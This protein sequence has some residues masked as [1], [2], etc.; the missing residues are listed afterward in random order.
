MVEE[1]D[2]YGN[3]ETGDNSTVITAS[4]S[5]GN[6]PLLGTTTATVAGGVA[7]V[8]Q[9]GRQLGRDDHAGLHR[10]RPVSRAV[11]PDRRQP[12]GGHP[13]G[14]PDPARIRSVTAGNPLTDPIVIDEE[15]QYGNIVTS[16]NSTQVTAS[17]ASGAG[18][19]QGTTTVTVQD[20]VAIVQRPGRRQGRDAHAPVHGRDA[21]APST[22]SPSV[23]TPAA[24]SHW[25]IKQPPGGIISGVAFPAR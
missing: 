8:H 16:D 6:G 2:Q 22:S 15:D 3:L 18:T 23:V 5:F 11:Q 9:P 20:G 24:A 13:V 10:R 14:D 21:A 17:L 12:G 4:L 25:S 1:Q 7:D 19:L